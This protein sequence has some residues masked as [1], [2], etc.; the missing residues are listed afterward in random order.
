[1]KLFKYERI[2]GE[3]PSTI[4]DARWE[5]LFPRQGGFFKHPN[6]APERSALSVFHQLHCL[7]RLCFEKLSK[8]TDTYQNGIRQGYWALFN[9]A[10]RAR[11]DPLNVDEMNPMASP[12]HIRHCIDLLRQS[13]MCNPDLT[14]E[15]KNDTVGG[16]TGFGTMHSCQDWNQLTGWVSQWEGFNHT[17]DHHIIGEMMGHHH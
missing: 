8:T 9:A 12:P 2:Y 10:T 16:V 1:M 14:I 11:T 5:A 13:L 4:T 15:V 7:V 6:I 3:A 17:A